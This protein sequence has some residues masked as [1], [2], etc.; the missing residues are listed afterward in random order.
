M[1]EIINGIVCDTEKAELIA[2]SIEGNLSNDK[3][4]YQKTYY[5]EDNQ[6]FRYIQSNTDPQYKNGK[7]VLLSKD[8]A[9]SYWF[10]KNKRK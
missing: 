3:Y 8:E 9:L 4:W 7:I 6:Y 5:T 2:T 10:Q 1:R